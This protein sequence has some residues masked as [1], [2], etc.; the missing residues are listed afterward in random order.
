[1][2]IESSGFKVPNLK[3]V[4]SFGAFARN[5]NAFKIRSLKKGWKSIFSKREEAPLVSSTKSGEEHR[6]GTLNTVS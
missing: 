3:E 5:G 1:M 6:G 2:T 4:Y